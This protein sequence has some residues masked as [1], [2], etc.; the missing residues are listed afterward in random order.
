MGHLHAGHNPAPP[1][2]SL[3]AAAIRSIAVQPTRVTKLRGGG[4]FVR[5]HHGDV[6]GGQQPPL[7]SLGESHGEC[8]VRQ[9]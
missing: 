4:T 1:L 5:L 6:A 7:P 2:L 9:V 3:L 8:A